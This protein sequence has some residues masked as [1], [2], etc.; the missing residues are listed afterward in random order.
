MKCRERTNKK[1]LNTYLVN[2]L[3]PKLAGDQIY[4]DPQ[5]IS[6]YM[7]TVPD[8]ADREWFDEVGI[9]LDAPVPDDPIP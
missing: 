2:I 5:E 4:V 1:Y 7:K 6:K 3:N 8:G 9:N